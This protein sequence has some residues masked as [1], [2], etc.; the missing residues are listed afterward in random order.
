[1]ALEQKG[2][3]VHPDI[4]LVAVLKGVARFYHCSVGELTTATQGK[5]KNEKRNRHALVSRI[6]WGEIVRTRQVF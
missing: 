4:D 2:R 1:L 3:L 6:G 5:G